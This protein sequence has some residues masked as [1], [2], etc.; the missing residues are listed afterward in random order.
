MQFHTQELDQAS[1]KQIVHKKRGI[2]NLLVGVT[3][4]NIE[5]QFSIKCC[6][7]CG[8]WLKLLGFI[9]N[10]GKIVQGAEPP[11]FI[12]SYGRGTFSASGRENTAVAPKGKVKTINA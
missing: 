3:D 2:L 6:E 9:V 7:I 5:C 12:E 1:Q 4:T 8:V 10:E 11:S